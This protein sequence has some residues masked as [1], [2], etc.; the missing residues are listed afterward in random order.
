[1]SEWIEKIRPKRGPKVGLVG[2]TKKLFKRKPHV[3]F[4]APIVTA[5]AGQGPLLYDDMILQSQCTQY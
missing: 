2:Y 3:L 4:K 1:M 5:V